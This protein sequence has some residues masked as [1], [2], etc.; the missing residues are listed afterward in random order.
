MSEQNPNPNQP[1]QVMMPRP[2]V[3]NSKH[4][5]EQRIVYANQRYPIYDRTEY[6]DEGG[7]YVYY[8][9]MKYP[10]KGF[11]FPEAVWLNDIAKRVSVMLMRTFLSA[12]MLI[13]MPIFL[14]MPW[15]L[16]KKT[17]NKIVAAYEHTLDWITQSYTLTDHR[18]SNPCRTLKKLVYEF[19][20][21]LDLKNA[22]EM[23]RHVSIM[24]EYDDAYRYR[25]QDVFNEAN[26][27]QLIESPVREVRRLIKIFF[28]REQVA[29]MPRKFKFAMDAASIALLHPKVRRAF[30]GAF[31]AITDKE[32]AMLGL[33]NSDR[34]HV[35]LRNDYNF[36]GRTFQERRNIYI[37]YHTYS[38]C[39]NAGVVEIE[40]GKQSCRKCNKEC[41]FYQEFPPEVEVKS[42]E[43]NQRKT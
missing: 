26:R 15:P 20:K 7:I 31:A 33:D 17:I 37:D 38:K 43:L 4:I 40:P 14:L 19:I 6:P 30:K 23:S 5:L 13:Y 27:Q 21:G 11:P 2:D 39:C 8:K 24:I 36:L 34:Y 25:M 16:K 22:T 9:G 42:S 32:F 29:K 3:F 12:D 18:L 41:E 1:A 10:R 35:L 28:E